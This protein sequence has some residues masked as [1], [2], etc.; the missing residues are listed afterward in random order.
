[1]TSS[2]H[3]TPLFP[4]VGLVGFVPDRWTMPWQPRHQVMRRLAEFFQVTWVTP[5][6]EWRRILRP[7]RREDP[8]PLPGLELYEP[9]RYLPL[10]YRPATVGRL[11]EHG[12]LRQIRRRLASRGATRLVIY[13]WRP[14]FAGALAAP[15]DLSVYHI[16]DD[17]SFDQARVGMG[18][19]ELDLLRRVNQVIIHSPRLMEL[20]GG[21]NPRTVW[22]P[23]GVDYAAFAA[24]G[25]EPADL[26]AIPRPRVG[27]AGWLK[28]QLDWGL[29]D[30]VAARC[31][32]LSFV[33]VGRAKQVDELGSYRA[34][35]ARKNVFSLGEKAPA[36][37]AAYPKHFDVCTMPYVVDR[38]TDCIYPLKLHEYLASGR[39][40]VGTPIRSL[41][42][43]REVVALATGPDAWCEALRG[44]LSPSPDDRERTRQRQRVARAHDWWKLTGRIAEVIAAGLDLPDADRIAARAAERVG[45][46]GSGDEPWPLPAIS[47]DHT[48]AGRIT[49]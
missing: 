36:D 24:P 18:P 35:L 12:R 10:V 22:V 37:L 44:A 45:A 38:Y 3:T 23:N 7:R 32:D 2:L 17:Y 29:L 31:P 6:L 11:F 41:Q 16:D 26:A 43:F 5:P 39:P 4:D 46:H 27:Y 8:N 21:V 49:P 30:A 47:E 9:P 19:G 48:S 28:P 40:V 33:L 20:K 25:P 34:F 14:H 13:L 15:H 42:G 1:M